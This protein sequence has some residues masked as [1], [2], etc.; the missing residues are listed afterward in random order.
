MHFFL[1]LFIPALMA[2]VIATDSKYNLK[3]LSPPIF[4]GFFAGIIVSAFIEF[5]VNSETIPGS[6]FFSIMLP[7]STG[8]LL[9]SIILPALFIFFSKDDNE[10]KA[11][12]ILPLLGAFYSIYTPY[13]TL[14]QGEKDSFFMNFT[15]P[16]IYIETILF[17]SCAVKHG[18]RNFGGRKGN[19]AVSAV[20]GIAALLIQ[21]SIHALWYLHSTA[22]AA[23]VIAFL[24]LPSSIFVYKFFCKR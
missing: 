13:M 20:L 11:Y 18:F 1:L 23:Y 7:M 4:L 22:K 9:P 19:I 12:S 10:Y 2:C 21:P 14:A 17:F 5:F 8:T 24:L 16:L 15:S 6:S 3:K